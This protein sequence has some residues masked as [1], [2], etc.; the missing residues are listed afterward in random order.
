MCCIPWD[1]R[2]V[3][4][5]LLVTLVIQ[6]SKCLPI[7]D[8]HDEPSASDLILRHLRSSKSLGGSANNNNKSTN[9]DGRLAVTSNS[10]SSSESESQSELQYES[11]SR[12]KGNSSGSANKFVRIQVTAIHVDKAEFPLSRLLFKLTLRLAL[13]AATRQLEQ[14]QQAARYKVKLAVSIRSANTCSRQFASAVAAEE[15]YTRRARLFIVSGC[16]DA[17]RGVARLA[18][19]W[20]VPVMTAAGFGADLNDKKVFKS[21]VRVAFSLR[22]AVEFLF[23]IMRTFQWRKINLI[24]DE[25][26]PNS[27]ALKGSI[28]RH[29]DDYRTTRLMDFGTGN[30]SSLIYFNK[31]SFDLQSLT[32]QVS[33]KQTNDSD[34][35][36]VSQSDDKWPNEATE[37]TIQDAL[38]QSSMFSKVNILLIPQQYLRKFMLSVYDENMANGM[39]TFINMPLLLAANDDQVATE[40]A[41]GN[42]SRQAASYSS[43]TGDNVFV[44]RSLGSTRNSQAKQAFES[45]MSIYLR[46]PTSKA[47]VYFVSEL[48]NL[49]NADYATTTPVSKELG[50]S[51]RQAK[52]QLSVNPYSA[53]FY[54][55]LM[56]YSMALVDSLQGQYKDMNE[57]HANLS[58]LIR[59]RR[60]DN[61]LTGAVTINPNGD[62]DTDY[63]LDDMNH[64]TGKYSPVILY[65][66]DTRDIERLGRI[67]WSSDPSVGP[68]TD[69]VEC[70]LSGLCAGKPKSKFVIAISIASAPLVVILGS[71]FYF[72]HS[73]LSLESKL[74]DYWWKIHLSELEIVMTRRKNA[75]DGSLIVSGSAGPAGGC[76]ESSLVSSS[77]G[78]QLRIREAGGAGST[79]GCDKTTAITKASTTDFNSTAVASSMDV[80]YGNITLAVYKLAKVALKPISK[81]HQS[82]KLMIELRT[83]SWC[84]IL[85]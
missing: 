12:S 48:M 37:R 26:D 20:R 53:S 30:E 80:C 3:Q 6:F 76:A 51:P 1:Y 68:T 36:P 34:S 75:N 21:L 24:V 33:T 42:H 9:Y 84:T 74:V 78:G 46:T 22:A 15:Y 49:A 32:R 72:V 23:K 43:A 70:S 25:S 73:R 82:R 65:R 59:N 81:F 77:H 60:F 14:Q 83:V 40:P 13:E 47:Y 55:C 29:L 56:I 50:T 66:A 67:H 39:Y 38:R 28:E 18:S 62:R 44:W 41:G 69:S 35:S 16:D 27:L 19:V 63:T 4:L 11:K 8:D 31:I 10:S 64:M 71:L 45:L 2:F 54:D 61:M 79:V 7:N 57:L 5:L 58:N 52:I 85:A 17:I